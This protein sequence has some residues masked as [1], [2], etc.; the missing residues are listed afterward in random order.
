[1][2]E[3]AGGSS[4]PLLTE[5]GIIAGAR[6][7]FNGAEEK[8]EDTGRKNGAAVLFDFNARCCWFGEVPFTPVTLML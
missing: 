6:V 5:T 2:E 1:V 3:A 4:V 7:L 8:E